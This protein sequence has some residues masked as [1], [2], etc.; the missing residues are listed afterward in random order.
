MMSSPVECSSIKSFR[1]LLM[2]RS[3]RPELVYAIASHSGQIE[4]SITAH[5]FDILRL[6]RGNRSSVQRCSYG[7][8]V[9]SPLVGFVFE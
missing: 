2:R 6:R 5:L 4:I 7:I 3:Q 9:L 8:S 1:D